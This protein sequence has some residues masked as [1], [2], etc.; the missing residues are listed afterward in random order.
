MNYGEDVI[1]T[2]SCGLSILCP[3]IELPPDEILS[4]IGLTDLPVPSGKMSPPSRLTVTL[5]YLTRVDLL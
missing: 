4:N 3:T 2:S 1:N 5:R